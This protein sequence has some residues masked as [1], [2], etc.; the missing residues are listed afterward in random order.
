MSNRSRTFARALLGLAA[1]SG[2][3]SAQTPAADRAQPASTTATT[4]PAVRV[5]AA[6]LDVAPL[7]I[8]ASLSVVALSPAGAGQPGVNLSEV[9]V[10]I[11]GIL[12][13]NRQNYTQDEQISIRGFGAR[14]TF[15]VRG[16]R[17]YA[18][19]IPATMP[20][21]QGQVSHFNLDTAARVEVLRGP[22]SVLYGNASGGVVQLWSGDGTDPARTT[23]AVG[24]GSD[25]ALRTSVLARGVVGAVDYN[26]AASNFTTDGYR[27]HSAARR[28]S[29]NAKVG[30]DLG[31]QR[32]LTFVFN[33]MLTP[34]ADD[35]LGLTRAQYQADPRQATGVATLYDTRKSVRQNQLGMIYEQTHAADTWRAMVYAGQR[36]VQQ[37][38]SIPPSAQRNPLQ[39]GGVIDLDGNYGGSDLRWTHRGELAGGDTEWVLGASFD[40][41]RQ[42]RTGYENFIGDRLGVIGA[43]RRDQTDAVSSFDQYAQWYWH[44]APRWSLLLG[45]RHDVVRFRTRDHYITARNPDDSGGV[46]YTATTPVAGVQFRAS[47]NLRLHASFGSGFETPSFNEVGYRRDGGAGLAFDLRPARS[48]NLELGAKWRLQPGL[49]LDGAVFRTNTRDELGVASNQNGRSTYQNIGRTRRQ[50]AELELTGT[51]G[52][53]WSVQAGATHLRA[54]FAQAFGVC[55]ATPC[56]VADTV[57][58]AGTPLAGIPANYGSLRIGHDHGPGWRGGFSLTAVGATSVNDAHTAQAPG[59]AL[60]A[61]DA[62]YALA[63]GNG[64]QW[65]FTARVDNLADRSYVGSVIVN[66]G[67]QRFYEPGPGRSITLGA[68]FTF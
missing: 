58:P 36:A 61:V 52:H 38:L 7:D 23:L 47:D 43:L 12:A 15:G 20:D 11:P 34:H 53:G 55:S 63:A 17:L 51:L 29:A 10:G 68:R 50:G 35:P 37:F 64:R 4:L 27:A 31:A 39:S 32:H 59:Y 5:E 40:S 22:F 16:V 54:Q 30:I 14:A 66:D 67:N 13:R 26:L 49:Q 28:E 57:V 44:F 45:A 56:P 42:A 8:P 48:R 6:R 62:G 2:W 1:T 24:G 9:L 60:L 3:A 41:Q 21:G 46:D 65:L 25:G 19:G 18:D 33:R